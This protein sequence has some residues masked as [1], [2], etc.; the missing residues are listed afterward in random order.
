MKLFL[1]FI[2][3][4][5]VNFLFSQQQ[6][7][8]VLNTSI[9][10]KYAELGVTFL[11]GNKIV[12]ASSKKLDSDKIFTK[13]R[14]KHNR[15]L[16]LSL[17]E[18]SID[19]S[20]NIINEKPISN[21]I[22]NNFH[23]FDFGFTPNFKKIYFTSNN[24]G[25]NQTKKTSKINKTSY[26]FS[27]TF[28]PNFELTNISPL[29]YNSKA[30]SLR[31]PRVTKDGKHLIVSS[32]MKNGFGDYDLY[33]LDILENGSH[34]SPRNLGPNVNT[35]KSELFPFIDDNNTLYFSSY[36]HQ[37]TGHLNIYKSEL[38]NG[39]YQKPEKLPFPI[40]SHMDDFGFVINSTENT[41][42]F[43]S[44][45]ENGKGDVDIYS[46]KLKKEECFQTFSG[47]L[48]HANN[49]KQ[50][51]KVKFILTLNN[52]EP[53]T[54]IISNRFKFKIKCNENYK[55]S[56]QKE[57]FEIIEYSFQTSDKNNIILNKD[58]KLIPKTCDQQITGFVFNKN[59]G[60]A[61]TNVQVSLYS[62]QKLVDFQLIQN[63]SSFNFKT[64]CLKT[65]KIVAKKNKF[66]S[67][68]FEFKTDS[69]NNAQ[70]TKKLNLHPIICKQFISGTVFD[71]DS[72]QPLA[73]SII[74]IFKNNR[75]VDSLLTDSNAN[76]KYELDCNSAYRITASLNNYTNDIGII[77]TSN[78][79]N[80]SL[81]KKF[82]LESNT[83]F[84]SIRE[85]KMIKTKP[86]YFD[87][88]DDSIR[89][90]AAIELNKVV[91][92]LNKY[93]TIKLEVKSHTDSRAPDN[94]NLNLSNK[95]AKSTINYIISH[96]INP[97]RVSGR[98]YG[99]TQLI[100][101][102]SNGVKCTNAEHELNRRTEF[103]VIDE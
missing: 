52:E 46:F 85:Q 69:T 78:S 44:N 13:N 67:E 71:K 72:E 8:E 39:I 84:V 31:N 87:L 66:I 88:N 96:G 27:A 57:G 80:K 51:D 10:S 93:P 79:S 56:I 14:R 73:N 83:E 41:G 2:F 97:N 28:N 37:S 102:C 86:I 101:K 64:K 99:E 100:N 50:L 45:R 36:G 3:L 95:R 26:I 90:D 22:F 55:L 11:E 16:Y 60:K 70:L 94:Y 62:N 24:Y 6:E 1:K 40:N 7:F 15:E 42:Y 34:T 33:I 65:Y 68:E 19:E 29:R 98:G 12:F 18:G 103:I 53:E 5:T 47:L 75:L 20:G 38:A 91:D 82:Y 32:N 25:S 89:K 30:Y 77:R 23:E 9:N 49:G 76:Y 59:T 21:D 48:L 74:K 58:F 54:K 61:L 81:I 92:I 17:F 4:F 35:K 63:D 43:T